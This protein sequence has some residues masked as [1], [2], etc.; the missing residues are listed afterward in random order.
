MINLKS[1]KKQN[2]VRVLFLLVLFFVGN[3]YMANPINSKVNREINSYTLTNVDILRTSGHWN[4]APFV[5]D[6]SGGGD[7]TW[8]EASAETWCSGSGTLEEPYLIENVTVNGGNLG[9]CITIN[10]SAKYF[11]IENCTVF[12]SGVGTYDAGIRLDH[13]GNGTLINNNCSFNNRYGIFI[14]Y[15]DNTTVSGNT[16]NDNHHNGIYVRYSNKTTVSGNTVNN[17]DAQGI[18]LYDSDNN[19]VSGNTVNNNNYHGIMIYFSDNTTV[20]GNTANNNQDNGIL[21]Y[22]SDNNTISGNIAN[23]NSFNGIYLYDSDNNTVLGNTANN[24]SY[25]GIY[26]CFSNNNTISGNI[27]DNNVIYG[28]LVSSESDYN[29]IY[30]NYFNDNNINAYDSGTDNKWDN[31]TIG[32]YWDDYDGVDAND[33]GIGDTP[34]LI[35]GIGEGQDNY[36]I[37]ADGDD[38]VITIILPLP[39]SIFGLDA[40]NYQITIDEVN[41]DTI[42]YTLDGGGT[43]YTITSLTG[44]LNQL[45]WEALSGGSI[46]IRFYANDSTGNVGYAAA[47]VEKDISAPVITIIFPLPDS[48]FGLVAP[49][50][51]ITIDEVNLD[52][53]WY[54]LDGGGTNYTITSLTGTLNQFA[55][56]ALSEGSITIRFYA[57]DT[58]GNIGFTDVEVI[59]EIPEDLD[60]VPIISFGNY[61]VLFAFIA[62]LSFIILE[63][64]KQK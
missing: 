57:N 32:N 17:N 53:I 20:L 18:Y 49:N 46:T 22:Y 13:A 1:K 28:I 27:V 61:Y 63:K 12:N 19:T 38:I 40:P 21:I 25:F 33:D 34:Y 10:N 2:I 30:K 50:Y 23:Y 39:N 26:L 15:S 7:Y 16:A 36:P 9:S 43:N 42:W 64:R 5:I 58:A 3:Y 45:A 60:G 59:I 24:N 14:T 48:I 44:T 4:L 52:T 41:L 54:T 47:T 11:R 51:N 37:W 56:E 6:D 8:E 35:S 31:G 62:T 55:W 29:L